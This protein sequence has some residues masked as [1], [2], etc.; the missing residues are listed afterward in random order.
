VIS[1]RG[2]PPPDPDVEAWPWPIK[3]YT[4]GRFVVM[5]NDQPVE[6]TGKAQRKPIE[7]LKALIA[8]GGRGVPAER[9]VDALWPATE[10]TGGQKALEIT[11]H[12]LRK[13]LGANGALRVSDRCVTLD[14]AS[15]WADAWSLD[16]M[17][18]RTVPATD[19]GWPAIDA[20]EAVAAQSLR[21]FR[22]GFLAD[23]GDA[24]WQ[25]PLRHRLSGRF[26][27]LVLHLGERW[28]CAGE[29]SRA[30]VLYQRA[31]EIEPLLEIFYRRRMVCLRAQGRCAEALEVF[32]RCRQT[33][34]V[35]LAVQPSAETIA[36]YRA[37][38]QPANP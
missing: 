14:P 19:L 36:V 31:T 9:L 27:R 37:L 25:L 13:L 11:V 2:L 22:G 33:L 28:E 34:S 5:K 18:A 24:P 1:K 29:W 16:R 17:L 32:R 3:V 10:E 6:F 23:D 35:T 8:L 12:R 20:V 38:Q 26:Q 7:L 15:V 30:A 21:L 4:L